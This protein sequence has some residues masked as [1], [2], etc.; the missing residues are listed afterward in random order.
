MT[1]VT[2][3][4]KSNM[5]FM[6]D[7]A[8]HAVFPSEIQRSLVDPTISSAVTPEI[9]IDGVGTGTLSPHL[10]RIT[11]NPGDATNAAT[12]LQAGYPECFWCQPGE[13]VEI[14][15]D[16]AI[17]ELYIIGV[18]YDTTAPANY[19]GNAYIISRDDADLSDW[20]TN[21]AS[22]AFSSADDVRRVRIEM[23]AVFNTSYARVKV[24]GFS[25][26]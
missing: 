11:A 1:T 3:S 13:A 12:R 2:V 4:Q 19:T 25:Y 8:V 5:P 23:S 24:M 20:Q 26:A 9:E 15:S 17:T 22:F 14:T 18:D 7:G 6:T 16:S 10:I 21:M